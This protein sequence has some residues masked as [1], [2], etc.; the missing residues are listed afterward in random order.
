MAWASLY[1]V[2]ANYDAT[3]LTDMVKSI[4]GGATGALGNIRMEGYDATK[5]S[6]MASAVTAGATGAL[7]DITMAHPWAS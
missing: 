6:A 5:L 4:T 1:A 3:K 2:M 7:G